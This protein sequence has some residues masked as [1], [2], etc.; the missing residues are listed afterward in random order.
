MPWGTCLSCGEGLWTG[1]FMGRALPRPL[2]CSH[3]PGV[4]CHCFPLVFCLE[5]TCTGV[6]LSIFLLYLMSHKGF[7]G[8][9]VC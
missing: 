7:S 4:P 1:T 6:P 2:L 9:F 3:V 5:G 8:L